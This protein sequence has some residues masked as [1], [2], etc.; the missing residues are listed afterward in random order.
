MEWL[1]HFKIWDLC[2]TL[3]NHVDFIVNIITVNINKGSDSGD[4]SGGGGEW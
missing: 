1:L 4:G 3:K 2:G